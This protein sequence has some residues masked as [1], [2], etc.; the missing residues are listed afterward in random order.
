MLMGVVDY[1]H[2]FWDVWILHLLL[3]YVDSANVLGYVDSAYAF[4]ICG[5]CICS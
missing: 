4:G 1:A 2:A 5:F 3:G